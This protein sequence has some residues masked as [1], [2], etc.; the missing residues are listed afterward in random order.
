MSPSASGDTPAGFDPAGV[1]AS[2]E[3]GQE[4]PSR[5]GATDGRDPASDL[6]AAPDQ[7]AGSDQGAG[8]AEGTWWQ[9]SLS[10]PP[11]SQA[12]D[13][14]ALPGSP[15]AEPLDHSRQN[16]AWVAFRHWRRSRPFWGGLLITA[17]GVEIL[18]TEKAPL[19]VVLHVGTQ[20]L[21]G[22]LLPAMMILCGLLLWFAP[23]QRTFYSVLSVLLAL[24]TWL[25]S[26]LGGFLIGMVLGLIGGSLAF[27]WT[28]RTGARPTKAR[29]DKSKSKEKADPAHV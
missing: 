7:G 24:G 11:T 13:G 23:Q 9:G 28:P 5:H 15:E 8:A 2:N 4:D 10:G 16:R 17:G 29:K 25:T 26:N 1:P 14:S 27:G 22:Y 3:S 19:G 6:Y 21:A 12:P 20:G 18:F